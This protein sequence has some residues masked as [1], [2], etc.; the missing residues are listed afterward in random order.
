MNI[1]AAVAKT[2]TPSDGRFP[3]PQCGGLVHP[4]AGKCKH[5]KADLNEARGAR[6]QA[7]AALPALLG[8]SGTSPVRADATPAPSP[9]KALAKAAAEPQPILPPRESARM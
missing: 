2:S 9:I 7:K 5:C 4:I 3:C 1:M 6:P 8:R